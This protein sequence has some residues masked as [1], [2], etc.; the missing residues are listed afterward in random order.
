MHEHTHLPFYWFTIYTLIDISKTDVLTNSQITLQNKDIEFKRNQHRNWESLTQVLGLRAQ[1]IEI[2]KPII[3]VSF[4]N[5]F[6]FGKNFLKKKHTIWKTSFCVEHADIYTKDSNLVSGL[7]E[8]FNNVPIIT[9]LTET[10]R[11]PTALFCS[12]NEYKNI[13]FKIGKL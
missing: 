13:S 6:N 2:L 3:L 12:Y 9:N 8:D 1:P 10:I 5:D 4:T 7:E 11:L